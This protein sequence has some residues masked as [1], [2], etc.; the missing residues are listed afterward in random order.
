MSKRSEQA[1]ERRL[2][3]LQRFDARV[4]MRAIRGAV[5]KLTAARRR[6]LRIAAAECRKLKA[7]ARHRRSGLYRRGEQA[8]AQVAC[9][10]GRTK[11]LQQYSKRLQELVD[12]FALHDAL[13]SS[14]RR[15]RTAAQ[16]KA[17]ERRSE[18]WDF[19]GQNIPAEL[20][21]LWKKYGKQDR[22]KQTPKAARWERFLEW[23]ETDEGITASHLLATQDAD[24][25]VEEMAAAYARG[26]A[27]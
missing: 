15:V 6:L 16:K 22:F 12:Q 26:E 25:Y 13:L 5:K 14:T 4:H 24:R 10:A 23:A 18:Y 27:A 2:I 8:Q 17:A 19:E 1:S 20:L 21:P 9:S 7:E 11:A 3:N